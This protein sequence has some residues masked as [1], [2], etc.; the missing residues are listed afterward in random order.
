MYE[1]FSSSFVR[2]ID[3]NRTLKDSITNAITH[4]RTRSRISVTEL[5]NPMQAMQRVLNP[6]IRPTL[7][8]QQIMMA[9]TGFHEIFGR[10]VSSEEFLEQLLEYEGVVGKVDIFED[11]PVEIKTTSSIPTDIYKG[12]TSYFEQ[13]GMYCAMAGVANGR[14]IVYQRQSEHSN[15]DF[16]VF[17]VV[18]NNINKILEQMI[19]RRDLFQNALDT[20]TAFG[21]PQCEWM[22]RGCDYSAVC[23]CKSAKP[24]ESIVGRD[25]VEISNNLEMEQELITKISIEAD[26][27]SG[28]KLN[29]L[30][31]PRKALMRLGDYAAN[32][33]ND[34]PQK[35]MKDMERQGFNYALYTALHYGSAGKFKNIPVSIN[36]LVDR[37]GM[38]DDVP[39][40]LRTSSLATMVERDR[41][42]WFYSYYFDRLAFECALTNVRHGRLVLYYEKIPNDKFMVYDIYFHSR[43][44][45][46]DEIVRRI[47][48]LENE[49]PVSELP[50]CPTWMAQY[51]EFQPNCECVEK[52]GVLD[53]WESI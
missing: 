18:F 9:G 28:F 36:S 27:P 39:T 29:D 43:K 38:Y 45:I 52:P 12:R 4:S 16:K 40:I 25:E 17:D 44:A 2:S 46:N 1:P 26:V 33:R 6:E 41:L 14:L 31:F 22:H 42:P 3:A 35:N 11:V 48:L 47:E 53:A 23:S 24:A 21:L 32:E 34:S 20:K 51:C 8:R 30:V 7:D 37:V 15:L 49:A 19:I 50:A 5:V 13:L 10:K